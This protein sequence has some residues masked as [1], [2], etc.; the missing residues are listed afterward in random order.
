MVLQS[1]LRMR[2]SVLLFALG[3]LGCSWIV[4]HER[5]QETAMPT[6]FLQP[7]WTSPPAHRFNCFSLP[8]AD[9]TNGAAAARTTGGA[10]IGKIAGSSARGE[11]PESSNG[12]LY[13]AR[14]GRQEWRKQ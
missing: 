7:T 12:A 13:A 1:I 5:N 9:D 6:C 2:A 10:A 8:Q 11:R 4:K 3:L 14:K